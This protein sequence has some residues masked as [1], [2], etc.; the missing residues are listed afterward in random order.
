VRRR[1]SS[2]Y[3]P[4]IT[5]ELK[6]LHARKKNLSIPS[7]VERETGKRRASSSFGGDEPVERRKR[8][9]TEGKQG[10]N[11]EN[12]GNEAIEDKDLGHSKD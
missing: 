7:H 10:E 6:C 4:N 11:D 1:E 5:E 8:Q 2:K 12:F 3:L 9:R